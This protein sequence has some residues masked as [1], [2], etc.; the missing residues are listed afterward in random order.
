ME[1]GE[2]DIVVGNFERM[3]DSEACLLTLV[4]SRLS[5]FMFF[6]NAVAFLAATCQH[7]AKIAF[8]RDVG[9]L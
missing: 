1:E 7:V 2:N 5:S 4:I 8:Y 3:E 6:I 9:R